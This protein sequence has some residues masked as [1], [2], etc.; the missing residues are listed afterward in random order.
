MSDLGLHDMGKFFSIPNSF[1]ENY[2][3]VEPQARSGFIFPL[4]TVPRGT[5][6]RYQDMILVDQ[7]GLFGLD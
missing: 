2:Q 6:S 4:L 3:D 5:I 7:S 1:F